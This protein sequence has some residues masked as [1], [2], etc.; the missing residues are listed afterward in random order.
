MVPVVSTGSV[1]ERSAK[2]E[3][4][5]ASEADWLSIQSCLTESMQ[6]LS[7]PLAELPNV[8]ARSF[9]EQVR[10]RIVST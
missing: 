7:R 5:E 2:G 4:W 8:Q 1:S 6:A 10:L 3:I 9:S